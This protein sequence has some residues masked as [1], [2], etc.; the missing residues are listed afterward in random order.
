MDSSQLRCHVHREVEPGF[1][2]VV[3]VVVSVEEGMRF[4]LTG[5]DSVDKGSRGLVSGRNLSGAVFL[6]TLCATPVIAITDV[7]VT[8]LESEDHQCKASKWCS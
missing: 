5:G 7:T 3:V 4:C 1:S 6:I 2:F 8:T